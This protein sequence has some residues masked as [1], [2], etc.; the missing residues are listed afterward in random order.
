M[1]LLK[2]NYNNKEVINL[3][4]S[5]FSI[6]ESSKSTFKTT[7]FIEVDVNVTFTDNIYSVLLTNKGL[8][9]NNASV[10]WDKRQT[11]QEFTNRTDAIKFIL[12]GL[13]IIK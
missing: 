11:K 12:K 3:I 10:D 7:Q 5:S 4:K 9:N 13:N 6:L 1:K 8:L 2:S